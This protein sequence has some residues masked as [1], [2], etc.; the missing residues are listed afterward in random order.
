MMMMMQQL[1]FS[2][3]STLLV[4]SEVLPVG[5]GNSQILEDAAGCKCLAQMQVLSS[6]TLTLTHSLTHTLEWKPLKTF[7]CCYLRSREGNCTAPWTSA[8]LLC[9]STRRPNASTWTPE[10]TC[11]TS[12][13]HAALNSGSRPQ[14]DLRMDSVVITDCAFNL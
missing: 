3:S 13:Y 9:P 5:E 10:T 14:D 12:R 1:S 11:T 8:W 7:S 4:L 2:N 6:H